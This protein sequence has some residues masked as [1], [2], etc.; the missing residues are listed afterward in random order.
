MLD[1]AKADSL[2]RP[3]RLHRRRYVRICFSSVLPILTCYGQLLT[4]PRKL[5]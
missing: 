4:E 1:V 2:G 5:P 3:V